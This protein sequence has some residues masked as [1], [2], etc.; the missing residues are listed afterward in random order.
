MCAT[1]RAVPERSCRLV[2]HPT[3][4]TAGELAI[5]QGGREETY[6]VLVL[7]CDSA[8]CEAGIRLVKADG[9]MY[10]IALAPL[11]PLVGG[12]GASCDCRGHVRWQNCKHALSILA[13]VG[14]GKLNLV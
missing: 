9:E 3:S 12:L 7:G 10:D 6:Q 13:L 8:V 11:S 5:R 14:A 4:T 1:V 2:R